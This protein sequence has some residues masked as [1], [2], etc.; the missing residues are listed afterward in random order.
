[1]RDPAIEEQERPPSNW[2]HLALGL[3]LDEDTDIAA[4]SKQ[5]FY[6]NI[7]SVASKNHEYCST[8]Q[9]LNDYYYGLG[10]RLV[11]D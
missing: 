4:I 2:D 3:C 7:D 9:A 8:F 10:L 6:S 1:M 5:S 11:T